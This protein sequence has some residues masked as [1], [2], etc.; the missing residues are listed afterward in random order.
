MLLPK[1]LGLEGCTVISYYQSLLQK[2]VESDMGGADL[3]KNPRL[4]P[5]SLLVNPHYSLQSSFND[6]ALW[7]AGRLSSS[8][9]R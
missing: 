1:A 9:L 7:S 8:A 6:G 5:L 4:P 2:V 3:D